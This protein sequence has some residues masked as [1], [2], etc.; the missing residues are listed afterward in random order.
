MG[1]NGTYS[2]AFRGVPTKDR[3]HVDT[4]MRVNGHKVLL[5]KKSPRQSKNILNSNSPNPIYLIAK[6]GKDGEV[7]IHSVN[8]FCNHGISLEVNLKFDAK[9]SIIPYDP[10]NKRSSHAHHWHRL[11]NGDFDRTSHDSGNIFEIPSQYRDLIGDIER[12]NQQKRKW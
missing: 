10:N 4:G 12:F 8:V 2:P 6:Q 3:T 7:I 5:Q 1:G 9:G 11:E